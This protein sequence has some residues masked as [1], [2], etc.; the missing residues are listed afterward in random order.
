MNDR[1]RPVPTRKVPRF[2][3]V[4][5]FL[6]L[7]EHDQPADVDVMIVGA[8]FD[9]GTSYRPGA[10]FG[11]R[12]VRQ[13]S[14]LTR[15]FHPEPGLDL[16]DHLRCCDGGDIAAVPLSIDET[17]LRIA[18]RIEQ[19]ARAGAVSAM[20]GGDHSVTLGA[21][22]GLAKVHGPLSLIHFDAHSD[23]Y[24]PAW[25]FDIHH[26]TIFRNAIEEGLL[27]PNQIVQL[28]IRG[29]LTE[30]HDLAF[31]QTHGFEIVFVDAIKQDLNGVC[32][33]LQRFRDYGK[34]YVSF[35]MDCMDPAYAPGTG[36]PVPGGLTSYEALKLARS[37]TGIEI[38]GLD[39]VEIS[40]DH[41]STGNTSLLAATLLA[42]LLAS[43]AHTRAHGK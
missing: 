37:L 18:T 43:L 17:L 41:D 8:P 32:A 23:T 31:A 11:P 27:Q 22:R 10:R 38:V 35:D 15:G 5:T 13:A 42:Q 14:A 28:G 6:R 40:P 2:A 4:S 39:V 1:F 19:I 30:A 9:G 36:T 26:G 29:P 20:V 7:P 24:G 34:V 25:G 3:G 12:G 21:L 33:S 16:F